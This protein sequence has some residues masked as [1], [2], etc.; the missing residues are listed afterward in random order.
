[1]AKIAVV[2]GHG[3]IAQLL[4]Q[5]L[6][7]RGDQVLSMI[8][9]PDQEA[10]ITALG[11]SPVVAD[12]EKLEMEDVAHYFADVD[13]V[14]FAAGAGANSSAARKR[15]VDYGAS[16]T[17][18]RAAAEM[19]VPR[20]I[21]ISAIGV[22]HDVD[23][24]GDPVWNA[25]VEAKR[26]ADTALRRTALAWTILRPGRL[27]DDAGTGKIYLAEDIPLDNQDAIQIPRAD[28]AAAVVAVLEN[29]AAV[30]VTWDLV[31]GDADAAEAVAKAL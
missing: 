12:F 20:F 8:R 5:Q 24:D 28:V 30:N 16:L 19:N 15:T 21:Q 7:K 10:T 29:P 22:D 17:A 3:Q 26:D 2:G 1:M 27:T 31:S 18:A 6:A 23:P 14:V 13:A 4:T 25:Y 9:N 11:G